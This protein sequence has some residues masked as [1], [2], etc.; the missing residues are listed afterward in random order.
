MQG[1]LYEPSR[2][3][4]PEIAQGYDFAMSQ[5][6]EHIKYAGGIPKGLAQ[7]KIN[8]YYFDTSRPSM[9]Q[10]TIVPVS[11]EQSQFH[12]TDPT[13][14]ARAWLEHVYDA[15]MVRGDQKLIQMQP[16][17][18]ES[19]R[20]RGIPTSFTRELHHPLTGESTNMIMF[21]YMPRYPTV[22]QQKIALHRAH[23]LGAEVHRRNVDNDRYWRNVNQSFRFQEQ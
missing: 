14:L 13:D 1:R 8:E 6:M 22:T 15:D 2:F 21:S 7:R 4:T 19:D 11:Y 18:V 12:K 20:G 17:T 16:D 5:M 3:Q 23:N 9:G 10:G